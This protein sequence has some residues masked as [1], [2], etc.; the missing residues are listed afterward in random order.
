MDSNIAAAPSKRSA[1]KLS[2][3]RQ[4]PPQPLDVI[5]VPGAML[6]LETLAAISGRSVNT[7]YRDASKERGLLTLTRFG[8]HCTRVRSEDARA[9]L[10]RLAGSGQ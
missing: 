5:N 8:T 1:P 9:Y 3:Q 7:L 2:P 6:R 4:T 10:Q